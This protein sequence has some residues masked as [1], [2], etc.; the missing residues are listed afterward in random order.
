VNALVT[1]DGA[2]W[3]AYVWDFVVNEMPRG[4]KELF[5]HELFHAVQP[6]LGLTVPALASEHLDA[7]DGRYWLRLEWRA[8]ARALRES[9]ALDGWFAKERDRA[10]TKS[11]GSN[12]DGASVLMSRPKPYRTKP[13]PRRHRARDWCRGVR[14]ASP[15][16]K[17]LMMSC[18]GWAESAAA[19]RVPAALVARPRRRQY[20]GRSQ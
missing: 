18:S 11:V 10:T 6:Q 8:L 12:R 15:C 2:T 20:L 4:R 14:G 16:L 19:M 1:W 7:V 5:L 9:G 17:A 13:R 3:G